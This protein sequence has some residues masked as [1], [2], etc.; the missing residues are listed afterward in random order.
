MHEGVCK[1]ELLEA[2]GCQ[3]TILWK[4]GDLPISVR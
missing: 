2:W 3:E 4:H 1:F